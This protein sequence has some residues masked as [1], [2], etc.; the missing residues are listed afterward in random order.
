MAEHVEFQLSDRDFQLVNAVYT[1]VG[2][3]GSIGKAAIEIV[4]CF[5]SQLYGQVKFS[6]G[7]PGS[8]IK[9]EIGGTAECFEVKGTEKLGVDWPS[10]RVS[11]NQSYHLL[12]SGTRLIRVC[13]VGGRN[14]KLVYLKHGEDFNLIPEPRWRVQKI[15]KNE[16]V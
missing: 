5:Y 12:C 2:H 15:V 9:I 4:K 10:L 8:D 11:S 3:N 16:I 14:I 6:K 7:L 13:G 1:K